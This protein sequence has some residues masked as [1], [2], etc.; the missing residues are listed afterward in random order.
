M[1]SLVRLLMQTMS[2][3][4]LSLPPLLFPRKI[5]SR[6]SITNFVFCNCAKLEHHPYE[7]L[8]EKIIINTNYFP[9]FF[10]LAYLFHY[11]AICRSLLTQFIRFAVKM[12][13]NNFWWH[14]HVHIVST[15][16]FRG[17][18]KVFK[19]CRIVNEYTKL[20]FF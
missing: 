3:F 12:M 13:E 17:R 5:F 6:L 4:F 10:L 18:K 20:E 19:F 8:V 16:T 14:V 1:E 15:G 7:V 11:Y 9:I 2:N